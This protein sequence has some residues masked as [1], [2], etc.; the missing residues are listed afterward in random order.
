MLFIPHLSPEGNVGKKKG[1]GNFFQKN[2]LVTTDLENSFPEIRS[3][4]SWA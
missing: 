2:F 3:D 4:P 1:A